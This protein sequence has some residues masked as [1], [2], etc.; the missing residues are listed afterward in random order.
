MEILKEKV[1]KIF[2]M[3]KLMGKKQR[4]QYK[5]LRMNNQKVN[6]RKKEKIYLNFLFKMMGGLRKSIETNKSNK[7]RSRLKFN[8]IKVTNNLTNQNKV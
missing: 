5:K 4:T 8:T 7:S 2:L 3:I 6:Q 1:A